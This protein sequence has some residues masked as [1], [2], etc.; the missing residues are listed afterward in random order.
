MAGM[1][2]EERTAYAKRMVAARDPSR[3]RPSS[4]RGRPKHLTNAQHDAAI[5]AQRPVVAK[6][7]KKMCQRGELP[8][9]PMAVE[10]LEAA[11]LVLRSPGSATVRTAAARLVLDFSKTKPAV[12]T[13]SI[14][15]TAED[16]VDEMAADG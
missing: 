16:W 7:M 8:E 12:R 9:D 13:E 10:A 4:R 14:V 15:M 3:P 11:L 6:I 1:S 5:D 2:P